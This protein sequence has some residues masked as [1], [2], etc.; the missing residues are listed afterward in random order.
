[1]DDI[2]VLQLRDGGQDF[3]VG[4]RPV[5]PQG[6][7]GVGVLGGRLLSVVHLHL[8]DGHV[9]G[10]DAVDD[11]R[12]VVQ[13]LELHVNIH[14]FRVFHNVKLHRR[15]QVDHQEDQKERQAHALVEPR[16]HRQAHAGRGPEARRRGQALHLLLARHQN[17]A[18]AQKADAVD[19]LGAEAAHVGADA[20]FR[21]P[22]RSSPFIEKFLATYRNEVPF[23]K[24]DIVMYK[25]IH[26]TVAFLKRHQVN[27]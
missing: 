22:L 25:E 19:D 17:G 4:A 11:F 26:K 27:Y 7:D 9:L 14:V 12:H 6:E 18:R 21:R 1:M 2:H 23:I 8:I 3:G 13:G 5:H 20:D 10:L 15:K 24:E 16:A